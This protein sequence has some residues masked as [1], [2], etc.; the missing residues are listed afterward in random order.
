M[1]N[2]VPLYKELS[3][4]IHVQFLIQWYI[5]ILKGVYLNVSPPIGLSS[6]ETRMKFQAQ[7]VIMSRTLQY[8]LKPLDPCT[9]VH[10]WKK[11]FQRSLS[12]HKKSI[13]LFLCNKFL[14]GGTLLYLEP[15]VPNSDGMEDTEHF[16][17]PCQPYALIRCD[18]L[19]SV[20][21][22]LQTNI[23]RGYQQKIFIPINRFCPLQG[24]G[25]SPESV[26]IVILGTK[27]LIRNV[28]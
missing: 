3:K 24:E 7:I 12:W 11:I 21:V 8:C 9:T 25:V 19:N 22:I 4:L 18:L 6:Q 5:A 14:K 26:K 10:I 20:I 23:L 2:K 16:L 17:L 13:R 15:Y 1:L 28:T 27:I